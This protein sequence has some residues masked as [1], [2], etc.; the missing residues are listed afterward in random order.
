MDANDSRSRRPAG[1][2]LTLSEVRSRNMIW[3]VY[4]APVGFAVAAMAYFL[5][6]MS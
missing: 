1:N 3:I 6:V 4:F 2:V 5:Y